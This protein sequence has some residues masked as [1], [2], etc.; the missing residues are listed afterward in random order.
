MT[1]E[2]LINIEPDARPPSKTQENRRDA[3]IRAKRAKTARESLQD[4]IHFAE[5]EWSNSIKIKL[6]EAGAEVYCS[7]K[8]EKW[9]QNF[10]RCGVEEFWQVCEICRTSKLGHYRCSNRFCPR[11]APTLAN[12]K[13]KFLTILTKGM[14]GVKH[15]VLTQRNFYTD[16]KLAVRASR[17]NLFRLRKQDIFGKVRGGC[18]SMEIT[19]ESKGYH[20]HW[21]ILIESEFIPIDK[22]AQSWAKLTGQEFSIC[23]IKA[24]EEGTYA[25]EVCKYLA[26]GSEIATWRPAE[27]LQFVIALR[28]TRAFN[29]FGRWG[30]L[31]KG[32]EEMAELEKVRPEPCQCGCN[33]WVYGKDKDA[34]NRMVDKWQEQ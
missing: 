20:L 30:G 21:H 24:V 4:S 27:I 16:L 14:F 13:R 25:Q 26:K 29:T 19:N 32:A 23:K 7:S 1:T 31:R 18:A 8:G 34:I 11:C 15:L 28:G 33:E 10:E 5:A 12:Q 6:R 9:F 22:I 17:K 3:I 2:I